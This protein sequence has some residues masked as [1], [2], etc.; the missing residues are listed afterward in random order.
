MRFVTEFKFPAVI[1]KRFFPLFK[2]D[3]ILADVFL[4]A[5]ITN[6]CV[7]EFHKVI[8]HIYDRL[9]EIQ[10]NVIEGNSGSPHID[11]NNIVCKLLKG[12]DILLRKLSD[13]DQAVHS[14]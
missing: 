1:D 3:G 9:V 12:F 11:K 5:Q 7:S 8:D 4:S 13:T 6:L 14:A 2:I 10:H